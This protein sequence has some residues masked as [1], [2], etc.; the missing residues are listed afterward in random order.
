M[1]LN[2]F[3][4]YVILISFFFNML[5][6]LLWIASMLDG[7]NLI[8]N[9]FDSIKSH[10]FTIGHLVVSILGFPIVAFNALIYFKLFKNIIKN[11]FKFIFKYLIMSFLKFIFKI[12]KAIWFVLTIPI[13]KPRGR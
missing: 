12:L 7:E 3:S 13:I 5:L 6:A 4:D 2:A 10:G 9:F 1:S 11:I 8:F